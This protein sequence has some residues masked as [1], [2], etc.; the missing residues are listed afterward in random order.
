MRKDIHTGQYMGVAT[1]ISRDVPPRGVRLR[2]SGSLK[3]NRPQSG[4]ITLDTL[5]QQAVSTSAVP[6]N[7]PSEQQ[8][9]S[10]ASPVEPEKE[11]PVL[12]EACR[13]QEPADEKSIRPEG[14]P[15]IV[16]QTAPTSSSVFQLTK[17]S[18]SKDRR[19]VK[20]S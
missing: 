14:T 4:Q 7:S 2:T 15:V 6:E 3:R 18:E 13:P 17:F 5:E 1:W 10:L 8:I 19:V 12:P 16:V 11:S 9:T 20:F